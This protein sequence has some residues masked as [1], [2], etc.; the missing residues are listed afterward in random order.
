MPKAPFEPLLL[1]LDPDMIDL[2][3]VITLFGKAEQ[4]LGEF[5]QKIRPTKYYVTYAVSHLEKMESLYSTKIEGTQTTIDEVY[6]V[7]SD[8]KETPATE[9]TNEVIRYSRA[10]TFGAKQI[11][12][13]GLITC[14][15]L[16]ELH[17]ILLRGE[18]VR[19]NS[20]F[21]PG[22][23]RTQ[24]N[25]VGDH[26][27]PIASKV[28]ELMGNLEKYINI[29]ATY[30]TPDPLP[31]LI[32]IA[33]IHAHFETIHPFPDGNGRVGRILIP[34]YLYKENV[35]HSPYF[36]IS[37]EL[38][39]NKIKYYNYLQGTRAKTQ[40]GFVEWI[41][42]F[43]ESTINQSQKDIDFIDSLEALYNRTREKM[44]RIQ[45]TTSYQKVLDFIFKR[46]IF[47]VS[48]IVGETGIPRST[49]YAYLR[50]LEQDR[51]L[52]TDQ[53]QRNRKYYFIDLLEK[54]RA[55]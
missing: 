12:N 6:E 44:S 4:K 38:E 50:L 2:R 55:N 41:Q 5:N 17:K 11:Q 35:I 43:L 16:K 34:L 31:P 46:P 33:I 27:P 7:E 9:D 53:K 20:D 23:F 45:N 26:I 22:A 51:I 39:K 42:F 54:I 40:K 10:L 47:T 19:K 52:F 48:K 36:L 37:Q 25:R 29:D 14:K 8:V 13:G 30:Q 1:P 32:R 28:D 24:Q 18:H 49:V 3:Q 15:L 21:Q